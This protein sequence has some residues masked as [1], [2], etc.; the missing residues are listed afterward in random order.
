MEGQKGRQGNTM[1]VKKFEADTLDEA[2]RS[3]KTELGPDAIILK[4]IT[5]KGLKGAFKKGRV[6][7][8]AAISEQSYTKKAKVDK[9]LGGQKNAFYQAPSSSI[10]HMINEYN[11]HEP[12]AQRQ[13][14]SGGASY[15]SMGLNR[16]VNTVQKASS[17]FKQL[18]GRFFK[19]RRGRG[20]A[21]KQD[22]DGFLNEEHHE[23]EVR[24][25]ASVN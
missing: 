25:Q 23:P 4:T 12:Q 1:Y 7:I 17:K 9:A 22:F 18:F 20:P 10:N 2:L 3:V 24:A 21:K 5:N 8:T 15:G 16:V 11:E 19:R 14:S 13:Q 6:E